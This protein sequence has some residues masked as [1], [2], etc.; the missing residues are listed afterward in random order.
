MFRKGDPSF[1]LPDVAV[2][3]P[4]HLLCNLQTDP[5]IADLLLLPSPWYSLAGSN[6][7]L[8]RDAVL[9]ASTVCSRGREVTL[10]KDLRARRSAT[11]QRISTWH[12]PISLD[13]QVDLWFSTSFLSVLVGSFPRVSRHVTVGVF[14][15]MIALVVRVVPTALSL[16]LLRRRVFYL[17]KGTRV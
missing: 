6:A 4:T 17:W 5:W 15:D 14:F 10:R 16:R 3:C 11:M 9:L 2:T 8:L 1:C 13:E 7:S 12:P